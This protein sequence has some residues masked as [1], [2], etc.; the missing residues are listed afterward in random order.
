[1]KDELPDLFNLMYAQRH[2]PEFHFI[3]TL[4]THSSQNKHWSYLLSGNTR[5]Y[6][7]S[8]LKFELQ[9][10]QLRKGYKVLPNAKTKT[11]GHPLDV[12]VGY[13]W[14]RQSYQYEFSVFYLTDCLN[15]LT[16]NNVESAFE[17]LRQAYLNPASESDGKILRE[18]YQKLSDH[19]Y[20]GERDESKKIN[21]LTEFLNTSTSTLQTLLSEHQSIYYP[22]LEKAEFYNSYVAMERLILLDIKKLM[23]AADAPDHPLL[24]SDEFFKTFNDR[25]E[26]I[27]TEHWSPGYTIAAEASRQLAYYY[28]ELDGYYYS[29]AVLGSSEQGYGCAKE[30]RGMW[31][32]ASTSNVLLFNQSK[33]LPKGSKQFKE[34]R[35]HHMQNAFAWMTI[36]KHTETYSFDIRHNTLMNKSPRECS[37]FVLAGKDSYRGMLDLYR[38]Q[39]EKL[40][41]SNEKINTTNGESEKHANELLM[42]QG[43]IEAP[44]QSYAIGYSH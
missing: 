18:I 35:D 7:S 29:G 20:Y 37:A 26:R 44:L 16:K 25:L 3:R 22:L 13:Y 39:L 19:L 23:A 12:F 24:L 34:L 1:M 40:N 2:N 11:L 42:N 10:H 31:H 27:K 17:S 38:Q 14:Y 5:H 43:F 8:L 33:L 21:N 41:F 28:N 32:Q 15:H 30:A 6:P 9:P 4:L 36:A